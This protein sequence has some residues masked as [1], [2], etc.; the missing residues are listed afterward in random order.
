VYSRFAMYEKVLAGFDGFLRERALV[1]SGLEHHY[2]RWSEL[3]ISR[4]SRWYR[5]AFGLKARPIFM[6]PE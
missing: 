3:L 6:Y 4:K 1:R 5:I 2:V